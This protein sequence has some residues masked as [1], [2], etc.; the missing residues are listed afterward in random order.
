MRARFKASTISILPYCS[1]IIFFQCLYCIYLHSTL[2]QSERG[3]HF[4]R[5]H[6]LANFGCGPSSHTTLYLILLYY[7]H[8]WYCGTSENLNNHQS[9]SPKKWHITAT[10]IAFVDLFGTHDKYE[11]MSKYGQKYEN[12]NCTTLHSHTYQVI[13]TV[14]YNCIQPSLPPPHISTSPSTEP[15]QTWPSGVAL[16]L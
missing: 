10:H 14:F 11:K 6:F 2:D 1:R 4:G 5:L 16:V 9:H 13:P 12:S 15:R 7:V 8:L 3:C